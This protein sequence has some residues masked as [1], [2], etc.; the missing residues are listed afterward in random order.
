MSLFVYTDGEK[1]FCKALRLPLSETFSLFTSS[2][3]NT[4]KCQKM[5]PKTSLMP[6]APLCAHVHAELQLHTTYYHGF[7][8][9]CSHF[10][11]KG[12]SRLTR[13]PYV[14]SSKYVGCQPCLIASCSYATVSKCIML[15]L[16][17]LQQTLIGSKSNST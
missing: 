13:P 5:C 4:L 3:D 9:L 16:P 15:S 11:C 1:F 6:D 17:H 7:V 8:G 12:T 10:T 14:S 2:R